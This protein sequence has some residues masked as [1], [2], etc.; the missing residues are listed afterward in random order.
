MCDEKKNPTHG[1]RQACSNPR[2]TQGCGREARRNRLA[3]VPPHVPFVAGRDRSS[4]ESATGTDATCLHQ[5]NDEHLWT[6]YVV[7]EKRSEWESRH[8]GAQA[9][10]GE[11]LK[12]EFSSWE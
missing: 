4:D 6:G 7:I 5:D 11:R 3:Y 10:A 2:H 9:L 12:C 8:Y 1:K